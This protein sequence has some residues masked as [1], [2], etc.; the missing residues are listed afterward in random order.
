M[1]FLWANLRI[2]DQPQSTYSTAT[3]RYSSSL[4][5]LPQIIYAQQHCASAYCARTSTPS[6][7]KHDPNKVWSDQGTSGPNIS[8]L[9]ASVPTALTRSP[10]GLQQYFRSMDHCLLLCIIR[11]YITRLWMNEMNES[12]T[13]LREKVLV[14]FIRKIFN[15]FETNKTDFPCLLYEE[16]Q[17][18]LLQSMYKRDLLKKRFWSRWNPPTSCYT[19]LNS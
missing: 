1:S 19:V 8:G 14:A 7:T 13:V 15:L 17:C 16:L 12:L 3:S 9:N 6:K 18:P 5:L 2:W 4:P 11:Q 10:V